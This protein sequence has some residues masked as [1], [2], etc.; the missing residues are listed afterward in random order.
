[1]ATSKQIWDRYR[2]WL[3]R[4]MCTPT[5]N[6]Y[7]VDLTKYLH[8]RP[9][10]VLVPFD[11]NRENDGIVK[12]RYFLDEYRG[13]ITGEQIDEFLTSRSCSVFEMMAGLSIR[14]NNEWL[15]TTDDPISYK[16]FFEMLRNLRIFDE[17]PITEVEWRV[18]VWID[19]AFDFDGNGSIFPLKINK[20]NEDQ[21]ELEIWKQL[22]RYI[23]ESYGLT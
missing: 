20:L 16:F 5:L 14:I 9:F 10:K 8:S 17:I 19:R 21:R 22:M 23:H 3:L 1:M 18:D 11:R 2:H 6:P 12:R 4:E 15:G 7:L 13:K